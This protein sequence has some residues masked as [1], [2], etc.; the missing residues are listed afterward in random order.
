MFGLFIS[1]ERWLIITAA[2][3][4]KVTLFRRR[5]GWGKSDPFLDEV[6]R[7]IGNV[8]CSEI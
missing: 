1:T 2:A 4:R 3:V 6:V 7:Q 5:G 8:F